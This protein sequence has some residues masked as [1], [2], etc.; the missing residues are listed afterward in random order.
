MNPPL[1]LASRAVSRE[2]ALSLP[3]QYRL[4]HIRARRISNARK[5]YVICHVRAHFVG[6][7]QPAAMEAMNKAAR[8]IAVS[9]HLIRMT[10]EWVIEWG[11]A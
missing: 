3:V 6:G 1:W 11:L 8:C 4:G 2:F 10:M 7:R 9:L 5:K